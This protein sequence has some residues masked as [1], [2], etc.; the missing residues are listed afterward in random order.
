MLHARCSAMA[1]TRTP[2]HTHTEAQTAVTCPT[3]PQLGLALSGT[4][5]N[6]KIPKLR[7]HVYFG[8]THTYNTFSR[9]DN[10]GRRPENY[11]QS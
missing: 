3:L 7:K 6:T 5:I 10:L 4:R 11:V 2:T 1:V 9:L 8:T